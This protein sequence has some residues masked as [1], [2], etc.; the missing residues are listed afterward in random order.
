MPS[1]DCERNETLRMQSRINGATEYK[2]FRKTK[3]EGRRREE[4]KKK[5]TIL[6]ARREF[7]RKEK[8]PLHDF[9]FSVGEV[10]MED[11]GLSS[12]QVS[13]ASV[14]KELGDG[15]RRLQTLAA[16]S[17]QAEVSPRSPCR[18]TREAL[19]CFVW[20][21]VCFPLFSLFRFVFARRKCAQSGHAA[22]K[23]S[24]GMA[25]PRIFSRSSHS[26]SR[27]Y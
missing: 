7:A 26:K 8:P 20:F 3:A 4:E 5:K 18:R 15:V 11:S 19:F 24:A 16:A 23:P 17:S 6:N 10:A 21:F 25:P 14:C 2:K 27:Q 1:K 22:S 12:P 13:V 9:F